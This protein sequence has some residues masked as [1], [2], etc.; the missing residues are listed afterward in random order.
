MG[1]QL[2]AWCVAT[3]VMPLLMHGAFAQA[4]PASPVADATAQST[5]QVRPGDVISIRVFNE[6]EF[7]QEKI[8]LTDAG[9][10]AF[11]VLGELPILGLT[12]GEIQNLVTDR[13]KGRILVN[14]LVTVWIDEYRP[15]FINGMVERTGA[16]PYQPGLTVRRAVSIAGGLKERASLRRMFVFR[17]GESSNTPVKVDLDSPIGPGDALAIGESFF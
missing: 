5:Y 14:P 6:P 17:E 7:T 15:F 13:L 1:R 9:T 2:F 8:R 4:P 10:V 12:V 11:F 3:V 16:Y